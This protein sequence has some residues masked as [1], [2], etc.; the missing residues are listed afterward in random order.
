MNWNVPTRQQALEIQ[1]RKARQLCRLAQC[2]SLK[3]EQRQCKFSLQLSFC[4][5]R[6]PNQ[7]IWQL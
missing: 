2:Q 3:S 1:L 7:I 4:Q 5:L 6:G